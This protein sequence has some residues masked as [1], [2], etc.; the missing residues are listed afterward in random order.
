MHYI[1]AGTPVITTL[2]DCSKAFDK[3]EFVPLFE[4][5]LKRKVPTIVVRI[6]IFVYSEQEAWVKWGSQRSEKFSISNGTRQGSVLSPALFAVYLDDLI[7]ELRSYKLGCH[8]A[9]LWVGA[10]CF[11]DDLLLMAPSRSAMAKMLSVCEK[12]AKKLNLNFSTDPDPKKSKSKCIFMT[13]KR[14]RNAVKPANLQLYGQDLPWVSTATHLGHELHQDAS[15]DHDCKCKRGRFIDN[16]TSVRETFEFADQE[17]ILNAIQIYCCD[18]YGSMLWNLF[19]DEAEKFY[20]CWNTCTKLVW[21]LPRNTPVYFVDNLLACNFPSIRKQILSRYVKFYRSLLSSPSKE[22]AVLAR[23]VG[24]NASTTTGLNILNISLETRLDPRKSP[25][26]K[27]HEVLNKPCPVPAGCSWRLGLLEKYV[28]LRKSQQLACEGTDYL[29][30]L[31]N[32]LCS[33]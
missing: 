12:Y 25:L 6:L 11:A 16:S 18:F 21:D 26:S 23:I 22:V 1:N 15:M 32:S 19:S 10:V 30:Q 2:L 9:G 20:R 8:M 24:G 31:I 29:D 27:F 3:C 28:N 5:L 4:K 14:M 7:V 13:G 17:Q 33:T